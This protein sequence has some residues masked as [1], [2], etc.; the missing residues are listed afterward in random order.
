MHRLVL[1]LV[2]AS[3]TAACGRPAAEAYPPHYEMNFMQA[4]E[5]RQERA[6]CAC[7]WGRI[8]AEVPRADFDALE[9]APAAERANDPLTREIEGYA[10][11]C[12]AGAGTPSP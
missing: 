1:I 10:V 5:A 6:L 12:N 4:C 9:R 2:L 7:I 11:A 3:I 8:S